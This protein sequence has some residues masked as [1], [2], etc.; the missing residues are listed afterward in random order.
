MHTYTNTHTEE[1][2]NTGRVTHT[3]HRGMRSWFTACV[4]I[5]AVK[6]LFLEI[7]GTNSLCHITSWLNTLT[8]LLLCLCFCFILL[9]GLWCKKNLQTCTRM[10][11]VHLYKKPLFFTAKTQGSVQASCRLKS[12]WSDDLESS[13]LFMNEARTGGVITPCFQVANTLLSMALFVTLKCN[14]SISIY[15]SSSL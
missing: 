10:A 3:Q 11:G 7:T 13:N 8:N 1:W 12:L 15:E 2:A 14:M 6:A 4:N 9:C 5:K